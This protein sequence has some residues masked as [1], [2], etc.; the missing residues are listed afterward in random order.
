MF[1]TVDCKHILLYFVTIGYDNFPKIFIFLY[2]KKYFSYILELFW[3]ILYLYLINKF[4]KHVAYVI[5]YM[6]YAIT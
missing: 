3:T 1:L 2:F 5:R 4:K 6:T